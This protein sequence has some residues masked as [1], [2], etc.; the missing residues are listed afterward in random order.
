MGRQRGV[1][2]M[3]TLART[4]KRFIA[5]TKSTPG[6]FELP[7]FPAASGHPRG[8]GSMVTGMRGALLPAPKSLPKET[9]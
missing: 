1:F 2:D 4:R 8:F 7:V 5:L 6:C 9:L 3:Y